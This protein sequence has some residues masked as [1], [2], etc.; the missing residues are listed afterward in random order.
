MQRSESIAALAAALAKAQGE[1]RPAPKD[2]E[3]PH[4]RSRYADLPAIWEACR[5]PLA[6]NGLSIVQMPADTG[7][8]ERLALTTMLMHESGEWISETFS[9]SLIAGKGSLLHAMGSALTY[10]RRY[11]LAA[12]AGVVADDDDDGNAAAVVVQSVFD[13][14]PARAAIA[15]L[16]GVTEADV[17]Q[18]ASLTDRASL[19]ALYRE[20]KER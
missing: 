18:A 11:A 19:Q 13:P 10:L 5:G 8:G 16:P 15:A 3:N 2:A 17:R 12:F 14:A 9:V 6:R 20:I 7:D 4:F 1:L